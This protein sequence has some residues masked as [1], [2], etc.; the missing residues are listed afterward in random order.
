MVNFIL[1]SSARM[2]ILESIF[3][4]LRYFTPPLIT[5]VAP[6]VRFIFR[7]VSV[8]VKLPASL[9]FRSS[10]RAYSNMLESE[11]IIELFFISSFLSIIL[12]ELPDDDV[13]D[14]KGV[15]S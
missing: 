4:L 8:K 12:N 2:L 10:R 6:E 3:A 1:S 7:R 9:K 14:F 11:Y 13:E 15:D 5:V